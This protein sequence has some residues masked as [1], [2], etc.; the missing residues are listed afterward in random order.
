[1]GQGRQGRGAEAAVTVTLEVGG[2]QPERSVHTR[3]V[4][5]LGEALQRVAGPAVELNFTPEIMATGRAAA[6]LLSMTEAGE[7]DACYFASSYLVSRVP[8]LGVLDLPFEGG[9][10]AAIWRRLDGGAG[11][12]I[13]DAVA[14]RTGF[15][16]LGFWDNGIRHVS[17]CVRPI[18]HPRDCNGLSI[19]TL[20]NAFHQAMFAA[21]GF[22][23]RF[24]DVKDLA[25]AVATRAIDAQENPLTNIVNFKIHETHRHVTLLGQFFGVALVLANARAVERWPEDV[26]RNVEAAVAAA[27]TAQRQFAAAEDAACLATLEADGVAIVP[28]HD[29]DLPAFK[30]AVADVVAREAARWTHALLRLWRA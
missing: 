4:R 30:S 6:D 1:M 13:R 14:A 8:E 11:A 20:D 29:V 23:P 7:L 9:D 22:A 21:L 27:T 12:I 5:V 10:R 15:R 16:V 19:R 28:L 26:R 3:A 18:R 2:Y 24:I 25:Q 17:N